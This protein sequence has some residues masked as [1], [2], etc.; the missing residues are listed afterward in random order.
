M[1]RYACHP[2]NGAHRPRE[3]KYVAADGNVIIPGGVIVRKS[4]KVHT[5][6]MDIGCPH[7][8]SAKDEEC[9]GCELRRIE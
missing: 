9:E 1:S 5:V 4:T 8:S 2:S 7:I 6:W 3:S